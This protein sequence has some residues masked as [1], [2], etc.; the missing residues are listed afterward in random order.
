MIFEVG[1]WRLSFLCAAEWRGRRVHMIQT[2]ASLRGLR[3][4][5]LAK[6]WSYWSRGKMRESSEH[7]NKLPSFDTEEGKQRAERW[8][9][10]RKAMEK[11]QSATKI[12]CS[13]LQLGSGKYAASSAGVMETEEE[14][15]SW[16]ELSGH[17][18]LL[19]FGVSELCDCADRPGQH[20]LRRQKE[21]EE[22]CT[23]YVR[24]IFLLLHKTLFTIL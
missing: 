22:T 4:S 10:H 11:S 12:V 16:Y 7:L 6:Q 19:P 3:W 2:E 23:S 17:V 21:E 13:Y 20:R 1:G 15:R 8:V 18:W 9:P 5:A 14:D 24:V